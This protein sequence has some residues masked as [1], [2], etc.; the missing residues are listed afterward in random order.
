MPKTPTAP[1]NLFCF[2]FSYTAEHLM[3]YMQD[4]DVSFTINATSTRPEKQQRLKAQNIKT[5]L[6]DEYTP[7]AD[8]PLVLKDTTHILISIPPHAE[9]SDIVHYHHSEALRELP[10]LKWIGYLS[11][12]G[13]Y[14]DR[15]GGTVT[16]LSRTNPTS[17]RGSRRVAAE[18]QWLGEH[19][20]HGLPVHIFRLSGIYGPGR[21]ALDSV[22]GGNARRINKKGHV[23]NRIHVD[24]IAQVLL[25]SMQNPN[26]ASIY[27][28]ADDLPAPSHEVITR[29]CALLG[30]TAAPILDFEDADLSPMARSF[31]NDYKIVNNDKIKKELGVTLLYPDYK[32]GLDA[33]LPHATANFSPILCTNS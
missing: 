6:F 18:Q 4:K 16:E 7:L 20:K 17:R 9:Y 21:S 10:N 19:K 31:Y 25:A 29:A 12:S 13:V 15:A 5:F 28:L 22:L 11:T 30:R 24:D 1:I 2:G 23:F 14:G 27:N 3:R 32:V 8:A 33:C 26:P